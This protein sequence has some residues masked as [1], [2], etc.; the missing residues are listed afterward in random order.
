VK[1]RHAAL[2]STIVKAHDLVFRLI[3]K[4]ASCATG[5]GDSE[6]LQKAHDLIHIFAKTLQLLKED[7]SKMQSHL[8]DFAARQQ[9]VNELYMQARLFM[10]THSFVYPGLAAEAYT[11]ESPSKLVGALY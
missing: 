6:S 7:N 9:C 5:Q 2:C 11:L 4:Q 3:K 8:A 10:P 1:Q